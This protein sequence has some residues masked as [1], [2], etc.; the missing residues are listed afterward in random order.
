MDKIW[1]LVQFNIDLLITVSV[2]E[3]HVQS[4]AD[5]TMADFTTTV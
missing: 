3:T 1:R 5:K 2:S 4:G